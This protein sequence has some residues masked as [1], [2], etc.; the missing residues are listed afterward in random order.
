MVAEIERQLFASHRVAESV[1]IAAQVAQGAP[2]PEIGDG[3]QLL[4]ADLA[5]HREHELQ[6]SDRGLVFLVRHRDDAF[7]HAQMHV[8]GQ[9]DR[10]AV[11]LRKAEQEVADEGEVGETGIDPLGGVAEKR[12][13]V[14]AGRVERFDQRAAGGQMG[15]AAF[16]A[17]K[18]EVLAQA[19]EDLARHGSR[20]SNRGI[21]HDGHLS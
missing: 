12:S 8:F 10:G 17:S 13:G 9:R 4:V 5:S 21:S 11:F 20:G 3:D 2:D 16:D 6:V 15:H 14:L 1:V 19:I 18:C 7:G